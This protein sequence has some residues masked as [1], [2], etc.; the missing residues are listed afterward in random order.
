MID[1]T[2]DCIPRDGRRQNMRDRIQDAV[3]NGQRNLRVLELLHNWCG[4]VQ[5]RKH[6][7]GMV[8][9]MTGLPIGHHF[10]ECPHAP[11]GGMSA[12]ELAD[13]ALDFHDRNCVDC[14]FRKPLGFPN[15]SILLAEREEGRKQERAE[16]ERVERARL[17]RTAR[18]AVRQKIRAS[19]DAV[20]ATTLDRIVELDQQE[21]GAD[22][23][24]VETA[25]LA[26]E[27]FT[28]AIIDHLFEL[29]DSQDWLVGPSLEAVS[30]LPVEGARLCNAALR[31]L[32]SFA[33]MELGGAIVEKHCEHADPSLIADALPALVGLANPPP[34]RF[35]IG[36][37]YREP[38]VGPL[39]ALY[40]HRKEAVRAGLKQMIEGKRAHIVQLAA[41]GLEALIPN[42]ASLSTFLLPEL[43][44]KVARA[45]RLIEGN[46]H[47][48]EDALDNIRDVLLQ[49]FIVEP[50]KTDQMIQDFLLGTSDEGTAELHKVYDEV[51]RDVR[52]SKG[53][54]SIA[55]AHSVAF[56]RLVVAASEAKTQEVE[57]AS[58]GCFHGEPY[59]LAPIAAKEIDLLLG[60]AAVLDG[61]LSALNDQPLDPKNPM[62]GM[63]RYGRKQY[64]SSLADSFVRWACISA[65]KTD[66]ASITSILKFLR[67]LPEGSDR[68]AGRIISNFHAMMRRTEGLIACLPDFYTAQV[69]SSQLVRSCAATTMGEMRSTMRANLPSLA[70]EAFCAQLA[71]PFL[72]VHKAAVR[73]LERFTLPD[74]YNERAKGALSDLILYYAKHDR[75][76]DF[77]VTAIDLYALRYAGKEKMA[78]GLGARLVE[79]LM[80]SRPHV[81]AGE[82]KYA[83]NVYE[84]APGY[85]ALLVRLIEDQEAMSIYGEELV[86]RLGE[87]P[88]EIVWQE[89]ARLLTLSK[90]MTAENRQLVGVLIESFTSA[91]LWA[92]ALELSKAAYDGIEDTTRNKQL[93]LHS[94][95]RMVACDFE[96]AIHQ[97]DAARIEKLGKEFRAALTAIEEDNA[98]NKIRRDPLRGLPRAH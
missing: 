36:A 53:K 98:A 32:R 43:I 52:F 77:L 91:G 57:R 26:P 12:F 95:L 89:R 54:S 76:D 71:D 63:E 18:E 94:A 47:E 40:E 2:S 86:E 34:S 60:S 70:F 80:K 44:A 28:P 14:K 87:L 46:Q 78:G 64:L 17:D 88:P 27:T 19:L 11:A 39:I 75:T 33:H 8:E 66:L 82:L 22:Q 56:R 29:I 21:E 81:V 45:N 42:D 50:V 68:L 35:S 74:E 96:L 16:K 59:D 72:I 83:Q 9:Q 92:G 51:L 20:S 79:M 49:S 5:V 61:Q 65:A 7:V 15:L 62:A 25:K 30:H 23:R 1:I 48:V 84:R 41:R 24:L 97:N 90:K 31:A 69:G 73:A 55:A 38:V 13:T 37:Q 67:G 85:T 3:E 10:L 58:S 6:G 4:H 93:R